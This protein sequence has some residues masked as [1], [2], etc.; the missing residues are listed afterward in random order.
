M[1]NVKQYTIVGRNVFFMYELKENK[2]TK[3]KSIR[4]VRFLAE[5]K[6]KTILKWIC[7]KEELFYVIALL[8]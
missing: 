8:A 7:K 6:G 5:D 3:E 4:R 2:N 1:Y